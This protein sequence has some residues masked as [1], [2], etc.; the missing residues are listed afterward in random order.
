MPPVLDL[1]SGTADAHAPYGYAS[2]RL[3]KEPG[4]AFGYSGG[5][6]LVLQH[7]LESRE[8]KPIAEIFAPFLA[9]GGHRR[10]PRP[11][12]RPGVRRQARRGGVQGERRARRGRAAD[13]PAA[14]G[15]RPRLARGAR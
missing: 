3:T 1:I 12:L 15:R 6:F 4:T 9:K 2:L 11:Q 5:G 7:L 8:G 14:G 13:V 10:R